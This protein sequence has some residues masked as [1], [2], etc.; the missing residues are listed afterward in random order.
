MVNLFEV[1]AKNFPGDHGMFALGPKIDQSKIFQNRGKPPDDPGVQSMYFVSLRLS[2]ESIFY[3][4]FDLLCADDGKRWLPEMHYK[5]LIFLVVIGVFAVAVAA[6]Y[7]RRIEID[8]SSLGESDEDFNQILFEEVANEVAT[9]AFAPRERLNPTNEQM[10]QLRVALHYYDDF[11]KRFLTNPNREMEVVQ[12]FQFSGVI[13][14]LDH[15]LKQAIRAYQKSIDHVSRQQELTTWLRS[16]RATSRLL[17]ANAAADS[18]DLDLAMESLALC[19]SEF[20]D[21][22]NAADD[23]VIDS[24]LYA[25][26][27]NQAILQASLGQDPQAALTASLETALKWFESEDGLD[28]T[29]E[30]LVDTLHIQAD[31]QF[32]SG[33]VDLASESLKSAIGLLDDRVTN[34]PQFSRRY[35]LVHPQEIYQDKLRQLK[36]HLA[37][38]VEPQNKGTQPVAN[39]AWTSTMLSFQ[40]GVT[41]SMD[42]FFYA[43]DS[44]EFDSQ[45]LLL[46]A[47]QDWAA[48]TLMR[49]VEAAYSRIRI[50][51]L[52]QNGRSLKA[53]KKRLG[54]HGIPGSRVQLMEVPTNTA[55]IRDFGPVSVQ[56]STGQTAWVDLN[57]SNFET[58]TR[59]QNDEIPRI[60]A[61]DFEVP[62]ITSPLSLEGGEFVTNG[63]GIA[64]VSDRF[65]ER[66]DELGF[67]KTEILGTLKRLFGVNQTVALAPLI[68]EDTKHIDWFVTFPKPDVVV[69]GEYGS[70]DTEN[71]K[72]LDRT[73]N[74]LV[75]LRTAAGSLRVVR[76]PMPPRAEDFFGGTYT[77]VLYANGL[78]IVPSWGNATLSMEDKVKKIYQELLPDW[79]IIFIDSTPL[80]RRGGSIHCLTKTVRIPEASLQRIFDDS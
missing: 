35:E 62:L 18:G 55:W 45:D 57:L 72:L 17:M 78:L 63:D 54:E 31:L 40:Y 38:V 49:T 15:N 59:F 48:E 6:S 74:K 52:C 68:G 43:K 41:L 36:E 51:I 46:L 5:R 21:L 58:V 11:L 80:G 12:V 64:L 47:W 26:Y 1:K 20:E 10:Q 71:Q 3:F 27:R 56:S 73:A 44:A 33:K 67:A 42:R 14:H 24:Q 39:E 60:L 79:E 32:R 25:A 66:N 70:E 76:I 2:L 23:A 22:R 19:I 8:S 7:S 16:S 53:V 28:G 65:L 50:V 4:L 9:I 61:A 13:L 69:V 37:F 30:A 77:N 75:G 34:L 29:F